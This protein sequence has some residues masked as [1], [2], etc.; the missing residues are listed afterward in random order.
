MTDTPIIDFV[1]RY[2]ESEAVRAHMPGHKGAAFLGPEALDITEIAGA[3]ELYGAEGIIKASERNAAALFGAGK[4]LYSC[5][6]SSLCIR[7]MLYLALLE[8]KRA[9]RRISSETGRFCVLA[10]RNAHKTL[11]TAAALLDLDIDWLPAEKSSLLSCKTD[12]RAL[13]EL[14]AA[15]SE[16]EKPIAVYITSPDYLGNIEDVRSVAAVCHWHGVPLLVDNAHGA[17]LKFLERSLHPIDL[18]ADMCCDSAHKTLP[19]LTGAAYLHIHRAASAVF[20]EQAETALA[21][22]ASTSPS[23]LIMQSLDNANAL[24]SGGYAERITEYAALIR[25]TAERLAGNGWRLI[26]DEPLK[27]TFMPKEQG[28][29]GTGFADE[30]R[31]RGIEPEFADPDFCVL[32]LSSENGKADLQAI[33][34][35][36]LSLEK[37]LPV[38]EKPPALPAPD[39]A[40]SIREAVL[41]PQ[42]RIGIEDAAGRILGFGH[43]ACPP[44]VPIVTA[45]ERISQAAI[46]CFRY[47]GVRTVGVLREPRA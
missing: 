31:K 14:L 40:V 30:L 39:R 18:G 22:F 41:A 29:T 11:M 38:T 10:G 33:E 19:C 34:S 37:R 24:L 23:Y 9:G 36:V 20:S 5:E 1:R 32:M 47:Y 12:I 46:E 25:E 15:K 43:I 27:L 13:D 3:D 17:Y 2:C 26:G 7:A 16:A 42:E 28:Y 44:A 21:L 6:G 35:A 8:A 4:T 45:G